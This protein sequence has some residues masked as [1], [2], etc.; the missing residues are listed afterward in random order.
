MASSY[1][2]PSHVLASWQQLINRE[3]DAAIITTHGPHE[4]QVRPELS[5]IISFPRES[6]RFYY[7]S[8]ALKDWLGDHIKDY[9]IVH[10]HSLFSYP[11]TLA[12][13]LARR[14]HIP[15]IIR[16]FGT[17]DRA[18]IQNHYIR[19]RIYFD[20]IERKNIENAAFIH[21]T[22]EAEAQEVRRLVPGVCIKIIPPGLTPDEYNRKDESLPS[23]LRPIQDKKNILFLSRIHPGKG[24][25]LLLQAMAALREERKDFHLFL[26][27]SGKKVYVDKM[28][29]LSR[30]LGLPDDV[31][32][33]GEVIGKEKMAL[34]RNADMF[35]LPSY[36]ES[37]GVAVVEA[38][39][40]GCPVLI[41]NRVAIHD[42]IQ[43]AGAGLI[44]S[45]ELK[46]LVAALRK[47]LD[48]EALR[49]E[50]KAKARELVREK[51][52]LRQ[53]T[54]MLIQ[55][56]EQILEGQFRHSPMREI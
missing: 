7:Y 27:G 44:F 54:K 52:D 50:M 55:S 8:K 20:L 24:L 39:A 2:G 37:F 46:S 15:Y 51:Y 13:R 5:R 30:R 33:L 49:V 35:I 3:H 43:R 10:I 16:P 22:S 23:N 48:D 19:K 14:R 47:L 17:L 11:S 53:S 45:T 41:S 9:D 31:T 32:F 56:Y 12:A 25:E 4:T 34:Y 36:H 29:A 28:H 38:M 42:E 1:G 21:C 18:C 26:A 6:P 40:S